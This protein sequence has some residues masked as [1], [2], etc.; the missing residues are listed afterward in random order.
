MRG[1]NTGMTQVANELMSEQTER[2]REGIVSEAERL[3]AQ[4]GYKGVAMSQLAEACGITKP[5]LYYY[6]RDKQELYVEVLMQQL[7]RHHRAFTLLLTGQT[8]AAGLEGLSDYLRAASTYD[9]SQMQTDMRSELNEAQRARVS[10]AFLRDFFGPVKEL[11]VRGI[12][13][14]EL[15]PDVDPEIATWMYLNIMSAICNPN[16]PIPFSTADGRAVNAVVI[17]T[18]LNGVRMKHQERSRESE[19]SAAGRR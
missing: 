12:A 15:W 3:F 11:F 2:R 1:K 19:L 18:L 16:N 10:Q 8:V 5:A 6:F 13:S 17:E 7:A 14:G 9:L 4:H